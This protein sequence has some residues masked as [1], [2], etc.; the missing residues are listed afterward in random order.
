MKPDLGWMQFKHQK[1]T[2]LRRHNYDKLRHS[3]LRTAFLG[4]FL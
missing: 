3:G 2:T 1:Q 4:M